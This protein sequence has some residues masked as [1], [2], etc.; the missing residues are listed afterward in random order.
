MRSTVSIVQC[1]ASGPS[2]ALT[3]SRCAWCGVTCVEIN[4]CVGCIATPSSKRRVDGV[5]DDATIQHERAVKFDFHT[6]RDH[7]STARSARGHR[8]GVVVGAD[9]IRA[10]GRLGRSQVRE[11][12]TVPRE[13]DDDERRR[14]VQ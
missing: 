2:A 8:R 11:W 13:L 14:F 9:E 1:A 12:Y 6:G 4:Q 10:A 7:K 5:E 3:A